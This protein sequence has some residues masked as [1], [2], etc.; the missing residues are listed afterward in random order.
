[1]KAPG[2]QSSVQVDSKLSLQLSSNAVILSLD[3]SVLE[4]VL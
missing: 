1:M 2:I 3:K 4:E